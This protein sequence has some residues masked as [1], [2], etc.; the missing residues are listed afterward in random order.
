MAGQNSFDN[1]FKQT[2]IP[3]DIR[4][5]TCKSAIYHM[6]AMDVSVFSKSPSVR[7]NLQNTE[8]FF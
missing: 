5:H 3:Q 6:G 2:L 8:F 1:I 4:C 7:S